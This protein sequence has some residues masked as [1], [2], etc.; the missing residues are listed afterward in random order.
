MLYLLLVLT[1]GDFP[2]VEAQQNTQNR[3]PLILAGRRQRQAGLCEFKVT[4]ST[5]QVQIIQGHFGREGPSE[6]GLF[7]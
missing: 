6:S 4:C 1:V 7:Q 5:K 2:R 3:E